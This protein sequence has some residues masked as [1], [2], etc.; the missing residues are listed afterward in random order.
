MTL[1]SKFI[2]KKSFSIP[3]SCFLFL[4]LTFKTTFADDK[5]EKETETSCGKIMQFPPPE[6]P[7]ETEEEKKKT[8]ELPT[9]NEKK[10]HPTAPP[11]GPTP[12]IRLITTPEQEI[13]M[14]FVGKF[15]HIKAIITS[16]IERE[17]YSKFSLQMI[18]FFN[19]KTN[20]VHNAY[21]ALASLIDKQHD[22]H[23]YTET[24]LNLLS[25]MDMRSIWE[26]SKEELHTLLIQRLLGI[27]EKYSNSNS[28]AKKD[29]KEINPL[30]DVVF[31]DLTD[32]VLKIRDNRKSFL[33][34][35]S[36]KHSHSSYKDFLI[37]AQEA[38]DD[39]LL[40]MG[41]YNLALHFFSTPSIIVDFQNH[42]SPLSL[43]QEKPVYDV[44][45]G[46]KTLVKKSVPTDLIEQYFENWNEALKLSREIDNV[47]ISALEKKKEESR[48]TLSEIEMFREERLD[49]SRKILPERS[50]AILSEKID[51][52]VALS[53][54]PLH[55]QQHNE[56]SYS[57]S[58]TR[59]TVEE[60]EEKIF[61][62]LNASFNALNAS[63]ISEKIH[64][65][66]KENDEHLQSLSLADLNHL[67]W[68]I[69]ETLASNKV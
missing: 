19:N 62:A 26:L 31:K 35:L 54:S 34:R 59:R 40:F 68:Q 17:G 55:L 43:S 12:I 50:Q 28:D 45:V 4:F 67:I 38:F 64:R 52:P 41:V 6:I 56:L 46:L 20:P 66:L 49:E 51:I 37:Q 61:N 23:A 39:F 57:L 8:E 33:Q 60:L 21:R 16:E 18:Q 36:R 13:A 2:L 7:K 25:K 24:A 29:F 11:L 69:L 32:A 58:E 42:N 27:D 1:C 53:S 47:L 30:E 9:E 22:P 5:T 14:F 3:M 44:L 65:T 15:D 63:L 10:A 48:T